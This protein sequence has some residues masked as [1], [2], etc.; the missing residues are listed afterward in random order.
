MIVSRR[1]AR[2]LSGPVRVGHPED[3]P[4]G[5]ADGPVL[6]G[7]ADEVGEPEV[8]R[9]V[10]APGADGRPVGVETVTDDPPPLT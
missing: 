2:G 7:V 6:V 3:L 9:R 5:R 4:A 1:R 8:P 10:A